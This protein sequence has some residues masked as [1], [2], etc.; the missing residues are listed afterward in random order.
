M[1]ASAPRVP[2][3]PRVDIAEALPALA[4]GTVEAVASRPEIPAG[5]VVVVVVFLLLQGRI[6]R[7][8]PK[9]ALVRLED[10]APLDFEPTEV[11][12]STRR[13]AAVS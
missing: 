12:L 4:T 7:R 11:V 10:D 13:L 2:A 9:L 5:L 8:D 1:P 6:D 3:A